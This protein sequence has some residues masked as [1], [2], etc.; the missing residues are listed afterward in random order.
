MIY[1]TK[2]RGLFVV[3][4]KSPETSFYTDVR[5]VLSTRVGAGVVWSR[6]GM[7]ASPLAGTG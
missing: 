2:T 7:L 1:C 4:F 5:T 3:I 6:A